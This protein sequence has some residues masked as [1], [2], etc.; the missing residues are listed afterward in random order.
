MRKRKMHFLRIIKI[1]LIAIRECVK[2][3]KTDEAVDM[4]D[5][6]IKVL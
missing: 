2:R 1:L 6:M 4:L 5:T 3:M